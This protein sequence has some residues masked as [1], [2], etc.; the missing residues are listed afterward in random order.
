MSYNLENNLKHLSILTFYIHYVRSFVGWWL[1][2]IYMYVYLYTRSCKQCVFPVIT[3]VVL[4]KLM[5]MGH[6]TLIFMS[7]QNAT[8]VV[9]RRAHFD[10]VHPALEGFEHSVCCE[11]Y[12][13]TYILASYR[14]SIVSTISH[15][16]GKFC[17]SKNVSFWLSDF[18]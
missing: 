16:Q 5:R 8:L 7:C 9:T 6:M 15:F 18:R 14:H 2:K 4:W 12:M 3:A 13:A 11:L 17:D 1:S 10:Y